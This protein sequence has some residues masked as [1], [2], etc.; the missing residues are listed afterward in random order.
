MIKKLKAGPNMIKNLYMKDG[1][2]NILVA[3]DDLKF[4]GQNLIIPSYWTSVIIDYLDGVDSA[5]MK[6]ADREDFNSF[7][8]FFSDVQ[9]HKQEHSSKGN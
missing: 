8:Q 1:G 7:K 3:V 2:G 4:D 5:K 9:E 6:G